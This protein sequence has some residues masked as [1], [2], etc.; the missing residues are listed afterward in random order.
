MLGVR[1]DIPQITAISDIGATPSIREGL[2]LAGIQS[3]V[4]GVPLVGTNVQGIKDHIINGETGYLAK[5]DD[6]KGFANGIRLLADET[7]RGRMKEKCVEM[8]KNYSTEIS[9][10]Q[11]ETIYKQVLFD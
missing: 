8:P 10:E 3:L 4:A 1:F 9:Q 5:A 7:T 6:A 2:G 11:M